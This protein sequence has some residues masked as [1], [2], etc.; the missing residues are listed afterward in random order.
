MTILYVGL[1]IAMVSGISA[2]MQIGN[3][4]NNLM[5]L[6]TFK[7]NEYYESNLP[8]YDR[9]IMDFLDNYSG[10]DTDVCSNL[11]LD[12]SDSLYEDG[13]LFLSTGT[14]T[15]STNSLFISSCVLVNKEINHRVLINKNDLG[16]FNLFSCYLKDQTFCPYEINK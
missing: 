16:S 7:N 2:M 14:Q 12:L 1:G 5:L 3:N 15:P 10:S 4:V 9:R 13:E 6:S 8:S 11:K